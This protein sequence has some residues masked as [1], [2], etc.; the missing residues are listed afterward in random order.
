MQLEDIKHAN[1][2][3]QYVQDFL[4]ATELNED[5]VNYMK[6]NPKIFPATDGLPKQIFDFTPDM[7]NHPQYVRRLLNRAAGT[8]GALESITA[9][10]GGK[11]APA[12]FILATDVAEDPQYADQI[13]LLDSLQVGTVIEWDTTSAGGPQI[14]SLTLGRIVPGGDIF[15]T[16]VYSTRKHTPRGS[17]FHTCDRE[18][19]DHNERGNITVYTPEQSEQIVQE[20]LAQ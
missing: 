17:T 5:F 19:L 6:G 10:I 13:N 2:F 14:K 1:Q 4:T 11:I 3:P 12:R 8:P 16:V 7:N 20:Y 15:G 9:K 18:L